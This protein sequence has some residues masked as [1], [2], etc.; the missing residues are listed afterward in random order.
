[1]EQFLNNFKPKNYKLDLKIDKEKDSIDGNVIISGTPKSTDLL[2]HAVNMKIKDVKIDGQKV[3][4]EHDDETLKII[5]ENDGKDLKIEIKFQEKLNKNMQGAYLST[6]EY[7]G[8]VEKIVSTQFESHYAREAF[9]CIDEPAAKAT[10]DLSIE[11]SED[12]DDIVIANTPVE[13]K[14]G[15]KTIFETTPRMSTYLLAFVIGK[16]RSKSIKNEHGTLI[17]TY[18]PL[19]QPED[20]VDFAN[21]VA[22][23]SLEFYDNK[24][25][26]LYPLE[27]LDQVAIP[28]FE[29]GAMENWGLVTYRESMLLADKTV[30]KD[31]KKSIALTVAHELSHQWFGDL[32]TMKWWDDLWLNE[33]FASVMEYIAVD[34]IY[35]DFNIWEDFFTGDCMSA[36]NRDAYNGVQSVYQEVETPAEIATLFDGAIVYAKGARLMLMLIR[37]M[38]EE[39]FLAGIRD[40]FKQF[41]YSNTCGDDLWN[42]LEKYADF[43]VKDFMH[44]WISQ[45]GYPVITEKDQK[46]FLFDNTTDEIVW[47]LPEISDDMSGH[48]LINL[49]A[50]EFAEKIANFDNLNLEQRLRLLIDRMLLAKTNL[51]SSDSLLDLLPKFQNE[52]SSSVW[53]IIVRIISHLKL[54]FTPETE[55]EKKFKAY[56]LDLI[57]P[58]M[59]RLG[60]DPKENESTDDTRVR[61]MILGLDFYADDKKNLEKLAERYS[62]DL[63]NIHPEIRDDVLDAK[64]RVDE[65][66]FDEYLKKYQETCDPELKAELRYSLSLTRSDENIDMLV[67]LLGAPEIIKPQ[68]HL[69]MFIYTLR[70]YK[71]AEKTLDWLFDNWGYV[72]KMTGEK[73][74]EDYP[75]YVANTIKTREM[76]DKF[77][78]F[79]EQYKENP[80]LTRTLT[81][82][83][84]EIEARIELIKND[85]DDVFVKLDSFAV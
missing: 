38:G 69:Y 25:E 84:N 83:K 76:A 32:V 5:F 19:N 4:F 57:K 27:K 59:K 12:S 65:T 40:Y 26:V 29:A 30:T 54:F 79:F 20:S 43:K 17:T 31:T 16:F 21:E 11:I 8:H 45:P 58:Q 51:V 60:F 2:F 62:C 71:A 6:Y 42:A 67:S 1:M 41:R 81:V 52:T 39:K 75:R 80:V 85:R 66:M 24:F 53:E 28:D 15:N 73:S 72:E 74:L 55:E 44:A 68:D 9:P 64:L 50:Q 47:P 49:S 34:N 77:Y 61:N 18:A 70:N 82:A 36:L 22:A 48:Y 10:F 7:D 63:S 33:S 46:R 56:I 78:A 14:E 37:L 35:P 13:K 3:P 23:K